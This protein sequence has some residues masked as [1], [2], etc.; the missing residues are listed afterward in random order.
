MCD[1]LYAREIYTGFAR[2]YIRSVAEQQ[3]EKK[4]ERGRG[5]FE[6]RERKIDARAERKGGA[7]ETDARANLPAYTERH[8]HPP[9]TAESHPL[10]SE[11]E[12]ESATPRVYKR[13]SGAGITSDIT[14]DS[15]AE[16]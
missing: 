2:V 8:L 3:R 15:S 6:D 13:D 16:S 14:G 9:A 7:G 10:G 5:R 12:R 4:R 1:A 11:R